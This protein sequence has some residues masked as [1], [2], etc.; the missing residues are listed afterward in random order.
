MTIYTI[1]YYAKINERTIMLIISLGL[2][3]IAGVGLS[4]FGFNIEMLLQL[5]ASII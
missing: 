2:S 3:Q 4:S 1:K 5:P